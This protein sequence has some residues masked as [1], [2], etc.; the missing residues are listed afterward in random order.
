M[1]DVKAVKADDFES[2]EYE[3]LFFFAAG[4]ADDEGGFGGIKA[5]FG[6]PFFSVGFQALDGL[7]ELTIPH[8]SCLGST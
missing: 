1:D 8:Y 2:L 3:L 7:I 5:E 6:L 4:R